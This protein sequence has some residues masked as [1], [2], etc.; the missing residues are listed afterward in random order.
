MKLFLSI[1]Y[2]G[3]QHFE[4]VEYFGGKEHYERQVE[5]DKLKMKLSEANGVKLIYINYWEDV[6]P[7]LI[8]EK[9]G[10]NPGIDCS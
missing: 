6:T 4:P 7:D 5:R 9:I 2:Q 10:I 1:E 8:S 3:K